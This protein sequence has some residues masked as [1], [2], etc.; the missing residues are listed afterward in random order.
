MLIDDMNR[1]MK[2]CSNCKE[3]YR[4]GDKYCRYCGAPMGRP[5]FI[6]EDFA[7]IYGPQP[8]ERTHKCRKCGYSWVTCYMIDDERFCPKCGGSAPVSESSDPWGDE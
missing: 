2:V 1:K 5:E 7:C 3:P 8:M 4:E 6:K